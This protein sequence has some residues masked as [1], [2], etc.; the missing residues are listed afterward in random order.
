MKKDC[1]VPLPFNLDK[2]L[3]EN[4]DLGMSQQQLQFDPKSDHQILSDRN[5]T[6][7]RYKK[8]KK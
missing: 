4:K 6:T 8:Q 2:V 3:Y 5:S 7:H 1:D